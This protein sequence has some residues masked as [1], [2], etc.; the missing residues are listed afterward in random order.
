MIFAP[1][2]LHSRRN[3]RDGAGLAR[4]MMI[5]LGL[6][7]VVVATVGFGPGFSYGPRYWVPFLPWMALAAAI[8]WSQGGRSTRTVLALFLL[9]GAVINVPGALRYPQVLSRPFWITP[10]CPP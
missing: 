2:A 1:L 4:H 3:R 5:P 7:A 9:V 6:F 10:V 8:A